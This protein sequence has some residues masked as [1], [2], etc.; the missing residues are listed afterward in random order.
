MTH[1][2][3]FFFKFYKLNEQNLN[4][5]KDRQLALKNNFKF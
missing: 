5:L 3:S 1:I 4:L 2:I